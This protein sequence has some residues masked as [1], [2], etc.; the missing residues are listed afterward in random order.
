MSSLPL[1]NQLVLK[2]ERGV[3]AADLFQVN[4]TSGTCTTRAGI[5]ETKVFIHSPPFSN[6][7]K[8]APIQKH[9]GRDHV[10]HHE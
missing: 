2:L 9:E 3:K 5:T 7:L 10:T 4:P 1:D 6:F 8:G